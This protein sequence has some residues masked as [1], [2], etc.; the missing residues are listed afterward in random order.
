MTHVIKKKLKT[1]NDKNRTENIN[2][3]RIFNQNSK[4][5]SL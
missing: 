2:Y 5:S 3:A 1:K 4:R